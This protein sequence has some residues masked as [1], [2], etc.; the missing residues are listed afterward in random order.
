MV[1]VVVEVVVVVVIAEDMRGR[2]RGGLVAGEATV[3]VLMLF[4]VDGRDGSS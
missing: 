4:D 2:E 1:V 3:S